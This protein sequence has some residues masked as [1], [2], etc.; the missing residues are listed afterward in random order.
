MKWFLLALVVFVGLSIVMGIREVYRKRTKYQ[1]LS[2][3]YW[4]VVL[5]LLLPIVR[6]FFGAHREAEI[7]NRLLWLFL[8]WCF[9]SEIVNW[10]CGR[11]GLW[12][13]VWRNRNDPVWPSKQ[14]SDE[15]SHGAS[16]V[17]GHDIQT[18]VGP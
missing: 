8:V 1:V 3:V 11:E 10:L 14:E 7:N 13:G 5:A 9:G 12:S 4:A 16:S 6:E 18:Q 15:A 17:T 2:L